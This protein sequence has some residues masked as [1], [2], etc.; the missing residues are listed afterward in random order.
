MVSLEQC[1]KKLSFGLIDQIS[2]FGFGCV[3]CDFLR[4]CPNDLRVSRNL[5]SKQ[6]SSL[7]ERFIHF[8]GYNTALSLNSNFELI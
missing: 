2:V 3:D 4:A 6:G 5:F 1:A 7:L 8:G